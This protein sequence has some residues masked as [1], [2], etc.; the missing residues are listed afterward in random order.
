MSNYEE[1]VSSCGLQVSY[2]ERTL[3][4]N[5][6]EATAYL[7]PAYISIEWDSSKTTKW[8]SCSFCTINYLRNHLCSLFNLN[9]ISSNPGR[10][11]NIPRFPVSSAASPRN[12]ASFHLRWYSLGDKIIILQG[13]SH[14]MKLIWL[15][16]MIS[17]LRKQETF[18]K[19]FGQCGQHILFLEKTLS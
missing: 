11:S 1:I 10:F 13:N 15:R 17:P 12:L 7:S 5:H 3:P 2:Q 16:P 19:T 6:D 4:I 8:T 18:S 9:S 14:P